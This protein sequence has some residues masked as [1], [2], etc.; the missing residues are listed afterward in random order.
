MG[1]LSLIFG[2]IGIGLGVTL[3]VTMWVYDVYTA[4]D[5]LIKVGVGIISTAI[6]ASLII[7][8]DSDKKKSKE[9]EIDKDEKIKD[10]EER[11]DKVE[12]EK[13]KSNDNSE[14]S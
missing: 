5:L 3:L 1:T 10:L 9:R 13:S 8:Y 11:L 2:I 14:N 4:S 6:G 7:K 12:D